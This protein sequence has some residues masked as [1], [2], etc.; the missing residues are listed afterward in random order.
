MVTNCPL[1]VIHSL[2][3]DFLGNLEVP[4][5]VPAPSDSGMDQ[6]DTVP[7]VTHLTLQ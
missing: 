7:A 3:N 6:T 1:D 5:S 4:G 2:S